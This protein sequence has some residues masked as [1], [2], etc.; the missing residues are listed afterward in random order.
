MSLFC[1]RFKGPHAA[2]PSRFSGGKHLLLYLSYLTCPDKVPVGGFGAD[3]THSGWECHS[4]V[5]VTTSAL[6]LFFEE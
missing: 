1:Q 6:L 4:F 3:R 2:A 5:Q